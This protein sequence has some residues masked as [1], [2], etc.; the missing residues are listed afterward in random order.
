MGSSKIKQNVY[1]K[2]IDLLYQQLPQSLVAATGVALVLFFALSDFPDQN[3]LIVW[4]TTTIS[5]VLFRAVTLVLHNRTGKQDVP[6]YKRSE[7]LHLAGVILAGTTWGCVGSF[8]YALSGDGSTRMILFIVIIGMSAGSITGLAYRKLPSYLYIFLTLLPAHIGL[9]LAPDGK[10]IF[11]GGTLLVYT[12]FLLKNANSYQANSEEMLVL[13]EKALVREEQLQ[14]SQK[15]AED[16]SLY[17]ESILKSSSETAII[18]TDTDFSI[19]YINPKAEQVFNID[20]GSG[21]GKNI[22]DVYNAKGEQDSTMDKVSHIV[23]NV[24]QNGTYQFFMDMEATALD[25]R[26]NRIDNQSDEFAGFLLMANDVTESKRVN[27]QLSKLSRAVEQSDSTIVI[28]NL[29]ATIEFV[30]PAFTRSTGYTK[31][32]A[33]GQNP[34][35]LKSNLQPKIFYQSMWET[36]LEGEVWRGEMHNRRKDGSL[37]WEHVTISPVKDDDTG[38]VTHYVAVKEDITHRKETEQKMIEM[39]QQAQNANRAKSDFLAN[40]S[41]DIRTPMSGIVGMTLLALDTELSSKQRKYLQNIK[42]SADSLLVLL[43]DILDFSKIEAGQLTIEE[44]SFNLPESMDN[45]VS[46]MELSA[47]EKGLELI[48]QNDAPELP[49]F[50]KGDELRLRQILVN[51]IGNSIKFTEDGSITL[52]LI[53]AEE[54]EEAGKLH[55]M[56]IDTGIGIPVDKQE[57]IFTSFSQADASTTRKFG[58]TGLGLSICKQLVELMGGKIWVEGN[59]KKGSIFHFT[60]TLAPGQEEDILKP[61]N[62]TVQRVEKLD[63]LLVDD[64]EINLHIARHILEKAGHQVMTATNGVEALE[65]LVAQHFDV[66]FMDVQM[67]VMDGLTATNI[68]RESEQGQDVQFPGLLPNLSALLLQKCKECGHIPIVA[69][70]ANAMDSDRGKCLD[71]GMD[72]YLTKPFG[73]DDIQRVLAEVS[74]SA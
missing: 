57:H 42:L 33:I 18:A 71:A 1:E 2:Q 46:M 62:L 74:R 6:D 59:R 23:E 37:Y 30:N 24:R 44:H 47:K 13:E 63:V 15:Y 11:I 67:P 64:N 35:V 48:L 40:M 31:E 21:L 53:P 9:Y 72:D 43:N 20:R 66:I 3:A 5:V 17:L 39:Q 51:L 52:K 12:F 58:G 28:T 50:V 61:D 16:N 38:K 10:S 73:P 32:E 41:H 54:D 22:A 45:I 4:L 27:S 7:K 29:D 36:L 65:V 70:T 25:V 60:V 49:V 8:L 55:F 34:R 14:E 56:V 68:I 69:M 19:K 26:I